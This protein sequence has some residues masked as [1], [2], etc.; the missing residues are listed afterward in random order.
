[1]N[2]KSRPSLK[3]AVN[4]KVNIVRTVV[5][6]VKMSKSRVRVVLGALRNLAALFLLGTSFSDRFVKSIFPS[7]R[8]VVLYDSKPALIFT[9]KNLPEEL[10]NRKYKS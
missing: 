1:M 6:Q 5:L 9:I 8:K 10:N 7:K 3:N 2:A 4:Q